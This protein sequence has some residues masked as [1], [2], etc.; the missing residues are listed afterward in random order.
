MLEKTDIVE[1]QERF[2]MRYKLKEDCDKEMSDVSEKLSKDAT[3]LAVMNTK[4]SLVLWL[5]GAIGAAVITVLIK[6]V[7]GV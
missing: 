5:L 4:L 1:L 2:D 6:I 7:F 3:R